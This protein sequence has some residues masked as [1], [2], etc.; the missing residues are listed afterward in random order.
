MKEYIECM[1]ASTEG[2]KLIQGE[3]WRSSASTPTHLM[4]QDIDK[5][6]ELIDVLKVHDQ[7]AEYVV[8]CPTERL[9]NLDKVLSDRLMRRF[10]A[11]S[12]SGGL[13]TPVGNSRHITRRLRR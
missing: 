4:L 11:R 8:Q 10:R 1:C 13:G 3:G 6:T 5:F 7:G 2:V 9:H 12:G